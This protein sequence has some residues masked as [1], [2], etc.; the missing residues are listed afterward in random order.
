MIAGLITAAV[1]FGLFLLGIIILFHKRRISRRFKAMGVVW[2]LTLPLYVILYFGVQRVL[3]DWMS[4]VVPLGSPV[5]C[6]FFLNGL[7]VYFL[8]LLAFCCL[9][10]SDHGLSVA[11]MLEIDGRASKQ[12]SMSELLER[13]PYDAL[14][15]QRL[16]HLESAHF[17]VKEGEFFRLDLKG[18]RYATVLG[19]MKRKLQLEPGG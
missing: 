18:R 9:Y 3:P 10:T 1:S 11:F 5:G 19:W 15:E 2:L 6:A 12:M 8:G 14:L 13:F 17:V 7:F 4:P 16:S